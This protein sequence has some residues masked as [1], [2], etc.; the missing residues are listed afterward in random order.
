MQTDIA[1]EDLAETASLKGAIVLGM[2][3]GGIKVLAM[4]LYS[5]EQAKKIFGFT[6]SFPDELAIGF[7]KNILF[8]QQCC[9]IH[10]SGLWE[11]RACCSHSGYNNNHRTFAA[12]IQPAYRRD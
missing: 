12:R 1:L 2:Q 10:G 4:M 8:S 5:G 7:C 11:F 6:P 3:K 9:L